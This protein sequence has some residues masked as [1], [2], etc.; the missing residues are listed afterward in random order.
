MLNVKLLLFELLSRFIYLLI[1]YVLLYVYTYLN[2]SLIYDYFSGLS[3]YYYQAVEFNQNINVDSNLKWNSKNTDALS[4]TYITKML[5]NESKSWSYLNLSIL[6]YFY[7]L[8]LHINYLKL[9]AL[10]GVSN[11]TCLLLIHHIYV[12]VTPGLLNYQ[13][14]YFTLILIFNFSICFLG[15]Y[16]NHCIFMMGLTCHQEWNLER[17]DSELHYSSIY[18]IV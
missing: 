13:K 6:S 2:T 9:C 14:V 17:L 12:Y 4:P 18:N 16:N 1:A 7:S 3:T 10:Y 11:L 8:D 15:F 5:I